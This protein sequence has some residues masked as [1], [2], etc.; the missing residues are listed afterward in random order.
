MST[1]GS[2]PVDISA[3]STGRAAGTAHQPGGPQALAVEERIQDSGRRD[4][5]SGS[6]PL[7]RSMATG[8]VSPSRTSDSS[9]RR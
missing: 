3:A 2:G 8:P 6:A 4:G 5:P 1:A 7:R 9:D